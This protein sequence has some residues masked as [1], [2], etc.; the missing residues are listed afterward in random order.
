MLQKAKPLPL[1]LKK[2]EGYI[3]YTVEVCD[4]TEAEYC[5]IARYKK[6]K[7]TQIQALWQ[8]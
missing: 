7:T 2:I 5:K 6:I 3:L 8:I 1:R 4:A